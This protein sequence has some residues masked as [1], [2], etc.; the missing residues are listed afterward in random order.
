MTLV[1]VIFG[2]LSTYVKNAMCPY[3]HGCQT[4][5]V[6]VVGE[7]CQLLKANG[8]CETSDLN[9]FLCAG[10]CNHTCS[11]S[12]VEPPDASDDD[13]NDENLGIYFQLT[14]A[15]VE[16]L[17]G[18]WGIVEKDLLES[19]LDLQH[20]ITACIN[21]DIEFIDQNQKVMSYNVSE[22]ASDEYTYPVTMTVKLDKSLFEVDFAFG[23]PPALGAFILT[24]LAHIW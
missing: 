16:N 12:P 6:P 2:T 3:C 8:K 10:T 7:S 22:W 23:V 19:K 1:A 11:G 21:H 24:V 14:F 20:L 4:E 5:D 9:Y 17:R 13:T 18:G 15:N